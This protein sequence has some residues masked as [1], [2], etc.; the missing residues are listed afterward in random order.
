MISVAAILVIAAAMTAAS[1]GDGGSGR[2]SVCGDG[3]K[4]GG[5]GRPFAFHHG[6]TEKTA[7]G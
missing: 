7:F 2:Y 1:A 4:W 5:F 6:D 3:R